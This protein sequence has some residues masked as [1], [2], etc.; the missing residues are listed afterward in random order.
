MH[1]FYICE[2]NAGYMQ[3]SVFGDLDFRAGGRGPELTK[4]PRRDLS[5][6]LNI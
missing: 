6:K 1:R 4:S 3:A 2:V 5:L